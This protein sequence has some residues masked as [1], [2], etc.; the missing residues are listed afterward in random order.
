MTPD[1]AA[2][3]IAANPASTAGQDTQCTVNHP[4]AGAALPEAVHQACAMT[5]V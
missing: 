3:D 4:A 1:S 5:W 2:I